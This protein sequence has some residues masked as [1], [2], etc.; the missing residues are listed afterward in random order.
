MLIL[1]CVIE[2]Q[3]G[4]N[5]LCSVLKI[6]LKE[7][8]KKKTTTTTS[9]TIQTTVWPPNLATFPSKKYLRIIL[10]MSWQPFFNSHFANIQIELSSYTYLST[11]SSF[12]LI[13]L[14]IYNGKNTSN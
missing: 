7:G 8:T 5:Y 6:P 12:L 13:S 4:E 3:L 11:F 2:Q 1:R 10:M 9:N 14:I